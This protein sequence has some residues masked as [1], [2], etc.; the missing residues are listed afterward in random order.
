M[1]CTPY[2]QLV[3]GAWLRD[4]PISITI[5]ISPS[6]SH[7]LCPK[8]YSQT[9]LVKIASRASP[10]FEN[11]QQNVLFH[12][13]A[14]LAF[15]QLSSSVLSFT[16]PIQI[17]RRIL[18]HSPV[19]SFINLIWIKSRSFGSNSRYY[20]VIFYI[21]GLTTLLLLLARIY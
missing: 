19:R 16:T 12:L 10:Q 6:H 4:C 1:N 17:L 5:L 14:N 9:Q 11:F 7:C 20:A 2:C 18:R 21:F 8:L 15:Y 13:L 3:V